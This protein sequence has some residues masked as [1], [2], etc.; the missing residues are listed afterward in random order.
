M[1]G[2][3]NAGVGREFFAETRIQSN[4]LCSLGCANPESAHPR[5]PRL[6]FDEAGQFA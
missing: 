1:S 3:D 4:F 6:T 2:F 5:G